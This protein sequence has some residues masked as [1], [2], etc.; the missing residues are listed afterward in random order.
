MA[1]RGIQVLTPLESDIR[2]VL[3]IRYRSHQDRQ[4]YL[5]KLCRKADR[6]PDAQWEELSPDL[7]AWINEGLRAMNNKLPVPDFPGAILSRYEIEKE[8]RRQEKKTKPLRGL[9]VR[10]KQLILEH[11]RAS[12]PVLHQMLQDEG[13]VMTL[14]SVTVIRNEFR[15]SLKVM[16]DEGLLKIDLDI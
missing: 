14:T 15:H 12:A 2:Q 4:E 9:K 11:P 10:L 6:L 8:K 13:N 3:G 16:R 5:R 1:P 7:Q